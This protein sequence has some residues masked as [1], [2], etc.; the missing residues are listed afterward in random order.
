MLKNL[1]LE[2]LEKLD[3]IVRNNTALFKFLLKLAFLIISWKIL[4]HFIWHSPELL[5]AY[6]SFSLYLIAII[7][8]CSAFLLE[9]SGEEVFINYPLRIVGLVGTAGVTIGEPCI[10]YDTMAFYCALIIAARGKVKHKLWFI[11]SGLVLLYFLNLMR[12]AGLAF[13]VRLDPFI[14]ELN[15]KLI[16]KVIIFGVLFILWQIWLNR[17]SGLKPQPKE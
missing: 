5:N 16:F 15:H 10:G 17:F 1:A 7:I 14:W 6:N 3:G 11:P 9:L 4:F 8:D 12:I 2:Y 13:L